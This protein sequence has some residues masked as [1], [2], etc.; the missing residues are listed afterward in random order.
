MSAGATVAALTTGWLTHARRLGLVA[1][2][3]VTVWGLAIAGAGLVTSLWPAATLLFVAGAV[4]G[5]AGPRFSVASG[6]LV[7]VAGVV[8]ILITSRAA[9][10]RRRGGIASVS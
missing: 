9:A 8:L 5:L 10:L 3:A 4:A 6:R 7:S 2:W 1:I